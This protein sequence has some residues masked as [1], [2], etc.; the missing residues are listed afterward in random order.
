MGEFKEWSQV[1]QQLADKGTPLF[2]PKCKFK[3]HGERYCPNCNL[4]I[5]YSGEKTATNTDLFSSSGD[6]LV[7]FGDKMNK[8]G[9]SMSSFGTSMTL[10]CTIPI[11]IIILIILFL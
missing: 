5:I 7:K 4:K 9:N 8:T 11:L 3:L 2:C 10:G 6:K 1:G